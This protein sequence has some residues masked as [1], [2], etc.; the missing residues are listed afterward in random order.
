MQSAFTGIPVIRIQWNF[1][2]GKANT[3]SQVAQGVR[4]LV[5]SIL[6]KDLPIGISEWNYDPGNPPPA[7]G[8]NQQFINEFSA[9]ALQSMI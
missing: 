1:C 3:Y 2:L 5:H 9:A 4:S 7:Y 6:G 8:D